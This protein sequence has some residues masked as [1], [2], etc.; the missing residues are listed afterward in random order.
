MFFETFSM[1]FDLNMMIFD[2]IWPVCFHDFW[3][4]LMT[5]FCIFYKNELQCTSDHS[6]FL[7]DTL[8]TVIHMSPNVMKLNQ[9]KS[10]KM[11]HMKQLDVEV[12][13][14]ANDS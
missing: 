8:D 5:F 1:I 6:S 4:F 12:S 14:P 9:Q 3:L 2:D 11:F 7:S 10:P 13:T